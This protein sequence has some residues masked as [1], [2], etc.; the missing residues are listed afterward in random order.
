[1]EDVDILETLI[2]KPG[3][4]GMKDA[5]IWDYKPDANYGVPYETW[6]TYY[7]IRAYRWTYNGVFT[8]Q[9]SL[10]E[11]NLP[12]DLT[13]IEFLSASLSLYS[14]PTSNFP[15]GHTPPNESKLFLV[16]EDWDEATVTWNNQPAYSSN[17]YVIFPASANSE[18]DYLNIDVTE[19]IKLQYSNPD[20]YF[21]FLLRLNDELSSELVSLIFASSDT[22]DQNLHPEL[23][24]IYEKD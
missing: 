1:M 14:N 13:I 15:L 20:S 19:L 3:G 12:N 4:A 16:T 9:R 17:D 5:I 2:L 7:D 11:F 10:F 21:G 8:V 6:T 22:D 24:I 23:K 18:E